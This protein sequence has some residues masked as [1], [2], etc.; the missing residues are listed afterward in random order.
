MFDRLDVE[1]GA[2]VVRGEAGI[3]KSALLNAAGRRATERGMLVLRTTG[4]QSE[5]R[6]PFAGLHQL[7]RPILDGVDGLPIPQRSAM[8]AAFG[9]SEGDSPDLFLIAL[10]TLGLLSDAAARRPILILAE[11]AEWLDSA[12]SEV[13]TF[14]GRR[15]ESDPI[16]LL[17]SRRDGAEGL[18]DSV[19]LPELRLSGLDDQAAAALM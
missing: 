2:L 16:V 18:L 4:V 1:G 11:D 6:M 10:A 13:L 15:L 17:A 3:G 14:V 8:L 19:E 5:A 7:L 9:V 12:T